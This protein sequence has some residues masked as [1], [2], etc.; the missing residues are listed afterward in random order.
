MHKNSRW[1]L[2]CTQS[3]P[4]YYQ[5]TNLSELE[6]W[7]IL[8]CRQMW[9]LQPR[10]Q[11]Q[12]QTLLNQKIYT[13]LRGAFH[14]LAILSLCR[15]QSLIA[16]FPFGLLGCSKELTCIHSTTCTIILYQ[17]GNQSPVKSL[18]HIHIA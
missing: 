8:L 4:Y 3:T 14:P 13:R 18:K 5:N 16:A 2:K 12:G 7:V 10:Q 9:T 15:G 11:G 6:Q 17:D 1:W